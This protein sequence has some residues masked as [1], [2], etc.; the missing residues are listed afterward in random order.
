MITQ[1]AQQ[2]KL[3]SFDLAVATTA[4]KNT[5]LENIRSIILE[6]AEQIE[7]VN[8]RD[9]NAGKENGLTEALLDRLLLNKERILGI[10]DDIQS[11][12]A[13]DDPV[14][15]EYDG[16]ALEN[17]L[18]LKKQIVPLGVVGVI[19]EARP[20]VTLDIACLCLKTGNASI[21]RG[22]KETLNTNTCLVELIG[23]A[24]IDA[25]INKDAVQ[26]ITNPDRALVLELLK[27]DKYIDMIIPRGG[28][29]LQKVCVENSTIPVIT[30]GIGICHLYVDA[31]ADLQ[32]ALDV[33]ENAKVQRPSVCNA[34]DTVLMDES[35]AKQ[36]VPLLAQRL[37]QVT[38][39]GCERAAALSE[40][41][42]EIADGEYSKEWL[43]LTLGIKVVDDI[44][45]AIMHIR[46]HSSGHSDGI[47]SES[48]SNTNKFVT[49]VNSAAVYVNASTRFT[50]G[51]QFGLGA[52]VAVSTQKLHARGPMGLEA[53]TTYKWVGEGDYLI[54]Q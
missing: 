46:E 22:G 13:M 41:V 37:E 29:T 4:Q 54:R 21:L 26:L 5:A 30:G 2:A 9:I 52:E 39:K 32:K 17:G 1:L 12:I 44:N 49:A 20:N 7:Q 16:K 3:A 45:Q 40:R 53:L 31:S 27:Q 50:D 14:G 11:L 10:A 18:R 51:S 33:I 24:L 28:D 35:I 48:L 36:L 15:G 34:L 23:K 38:L 42:S 6:N 47:L 19:Y 8:Q 25:G 43:S